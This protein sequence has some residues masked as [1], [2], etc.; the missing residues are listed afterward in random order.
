MTDLVGGPKVAQMTD[1]DALIEKNGSLRGGPL[2]IDAEAVAR[3]RL[4]NRFQSGLDIARHTAAIMRRDRAMVGWR[5]RSAGRGPRAS[6]GL[7][8][9]PEEVDRLVAALRTIAASP[10]GSWTMAIRSVS[11][12][13]QARPLRS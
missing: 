10:P 6:A 12:S 9:S 8:T 4:Q 1:Q 11:G 13:A 3:M 2:V 7:T 5:T